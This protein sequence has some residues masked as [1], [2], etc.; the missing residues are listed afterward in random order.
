MLSFG[1]KD[2][3]DILAVAL[4][5]FYLYR[6]L[7]STRAAGVFS[8]IMIFMFVWIVVSRVLGMRLIGGIMDQLVNIGVIALVVL[9]QEEIRHF[10]SNIGTHRGFN[11]FLTLFRDRDEQEQRND[12]IMP[13]VLAC[14][15]MSK[16]KVGA[17]IVIE[18][19]VGL[20]EEAQ[21]GETIDAA[22]SSRL[23][24]NIFFKNSP[25]HDG[26]LIVSHH[27]LYAAGC[28]LPVSH[29]PNLPKNFGL[30]HRS[31][32]GI[33]EKSDALAIIVSEETGGIS[34]AEAGR[35]TRAVT[36]DQL[37]KLLLEKWK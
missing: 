14:T 35:L 32:V 30:R 3:L 11:W 6:L 31:G 2:A 13:V 27:R 7:R 25:L 5:L 1:F 21:T 23:L 16:Q 37:E 34:V 20:K 18:R 8:G 28:I 22:I 10:F 29:D 15:A 17:L 19:S 12:D 33:T 26:A 9:F 36:P 4:L 24:E